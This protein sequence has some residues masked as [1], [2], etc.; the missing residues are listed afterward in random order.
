VIDVFWVLLALMGSLLWAIGDVI[1]KFQLEK[2]FKD[3]SL[4]FTVMYFVWGVFIVAIF[5][6][7]SVVFDPFYIML[8]SM[9]GF[10]G[11]FGVMFYL[12]AVAAEEASRVVPLSY[13]TTVFVAIL[14][15]IFLREVF[16]LQKY[17]GIGFLILGA[18]LISYKRVEGRRLP[19][20]PALSL[21]LV[22]SLMSG[23]AETLN[24]FFLLTYD[25]WSLLFW[26]YFGG[27]VVIVVM[28][29]KKNVRAKFSKLSS[30]KRRYWILV[31]IAT[32]IYFVGDVSW[33]SALSQAPLSLVAALGTTEP[34]FVFLIM[35]FLSLFVPKIL[36]EE[37]AKSTVM[38]K[39]VSIVLITYGAYLVAL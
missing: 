24:K 33:F 27:L 17:I 11:T 32:T 23:A 30:L 35:L 18:V 16:T 9:S 39:L 1:E 21:I 6:S 38:L 29:L 4:Y 15:Y 14:A 31:S 5:L 28:F 22:Y 25:Y 7:T 8:A 26:G 3:W 12:K 13:M 37:I 19:I 10:I 36:K 34:F 20:T 2:V